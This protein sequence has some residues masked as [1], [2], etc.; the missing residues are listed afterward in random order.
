MKNKKETQT[1]ENDRSALSSGLGAKEASLLACWL[2]GFWRMQSEPHEL[3]RMYNGKNT[4]KIFTNGLV[5]GL[6]DEWKVSC[7]FFPVIINERLSFFDISKTTGEVLIPSKITDLAAGWDSACFSRDRV[8]EVLD[9][10]Q[11]LTGGS[12]V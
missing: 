12:K 5:E 10:I 3:F 1:P 9:N 2:Y 4:I 11:V 8:Q 7:N 6:I